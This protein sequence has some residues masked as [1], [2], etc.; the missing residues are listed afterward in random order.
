[1][2]HYLFDLLSVVSALWLGM[3]LGVKWERRRWTRTV[4]HSDPSST[5]VMLD[6]ALG[7]EDGDIIVAYDSRTGKPR[8]RP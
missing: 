3:V 7:M 1:M 6:S 8:R 5:T 4:T 2:T